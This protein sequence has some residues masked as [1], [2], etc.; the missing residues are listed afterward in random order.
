MNNDIYKGMVVE[1]DGRRSLELVIPDAIVE[2]PE[3]VHPVEAADAELEQT[4]EAL[5]DGVGAIVALEELREDLEECRREEVPMTGAT[6]DLLVD[7]VAD[8]V[9]VFDGEVSDDLVAS[10]E[11]FADPAQRR[12]AYS[13]TLESFS[14]AL[15][16]S[17]EWV[18]QKATKL[19]GEVRKFMQSAQT[20]TENMQKDVEKLHS[21]LNDL[22]SSPQ[23]SAFLV[24]KPKRFYIQGKLPKGDVAAYLK[25]LNQEFLEP[26]KRSTALADGNETLA[27]ALDF[28]KSYANQAK[29]SVPDRETLMLEADEVVKT[30]V[31]ALQNAGK[32]F[33]VAQPDSADIDTHTTNEHMGTLR[34]WVKF[35]R[36]SNDTVYSLSEFPKKMA[37]I[38]VGISEDSDMGNDQMMATFSKEDLRHI[39]D[40]VSRASTEVLDLIDG[41]KATTSNVER[42]QAA[43]GASR[44]Q[45]LPNNPAGAEKLSGMLNNVLLGTL[46][47]DNAVGRVRSTRIKALIKANEAALDLVRKH[48]AAYQGNARGGDKGAGEG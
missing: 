12:M 28:A 10:Q 16:S 14:E 17:M 37:A 46:A 36:V 31:A 45:L 32:V 48:I 34:A 2:T 30:C 1:K 11:A 4:D 33:V 26:F 27:K 22:D 13:I 15:K 8:T 40:E 7:D 41:L 29:A 42:L 23:Q 5:R 19:L 44:L 43:I 24:E 47:F 21:A 25:K 18:G 39:L 9:E 38:K 6:H 3:E 20:V 35:P